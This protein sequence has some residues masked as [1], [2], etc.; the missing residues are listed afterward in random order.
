MNLFSDL[1][2]LERL[3]HLIRTR[4]TGTPI[5]LASRLDTS[6][7]NVYRLIGKLRDMGFP[8]NYDKNY[9]SYYY[10]EPVLLR[11]DITVGHEKL[12]AIH[13]GEKKFNLL[14]QIA[15]ISQ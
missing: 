6:E 3:D 15:R 11:I 13:G 8:I 10:D 12:L 14:E 2:L 1:F 4:A 7:R 5:Q 9:D